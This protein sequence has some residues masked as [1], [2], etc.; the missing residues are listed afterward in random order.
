MQPVRLGEGSIG[1]LI[2]GTCF[3]GQAR[4]LLLALLQLAGKVPAIAAGHGR[5]R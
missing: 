1:G 3:V 2:G 5:G 4:M